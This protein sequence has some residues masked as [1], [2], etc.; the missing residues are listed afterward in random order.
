MLTPVGNP[1]SGQPPHL[2]VAARDGRH[3][4]AQRAAGPQL[5]LGAAQARQ[6]HQRVAQRAAG[7]H[8]QRYT[9]IVTN[10]TM[11]AGAR[12]PHNFFSSLHLQT[13]GRLLVLVLRRTCRE[14]TA[15]P[16]LRPAAEERQGCPSL[17]AQR[18]ELVRSKSAAHLVR[19]AHKRL[20]HLAALLQA[21]NP[22]VAPQTKI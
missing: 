10:R 22:A 4:H 3:A 13:T 12:S 1:C 14:R 8:L 2:R 6:G 11:L 19:V 5:V 16:D 20:Q 17:Q 18:A 15:P 9:G 21:D 7:G